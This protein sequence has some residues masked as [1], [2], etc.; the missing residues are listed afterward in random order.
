MA[1]TTLSLA[2]LSLTTLSLCAISTT[3]HHHN[4]DPMQ[5][6]AYAGSSESLGGKVYERNLH[7]WSAHVNG[8]GA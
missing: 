3:P 7:A 4:N 8:V 5:Y 1:L 6:L 2:A